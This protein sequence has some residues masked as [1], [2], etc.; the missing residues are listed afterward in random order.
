MLLLRVV[1]RDKLLLRHGAQLSHSLVE[2][3]WILAF[4]LTKHLRT[5]FVAVLARSTLKFS[6][7]CDLQRQP[8]RAKGL[9]LVHQLM[10]I[11]RWQIFFVLKIVKAEQLTNCLISI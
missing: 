3:N 6:F 8:S 4:K 2:A 7:E 5:Y 10:V 9:L 1:L 11:I